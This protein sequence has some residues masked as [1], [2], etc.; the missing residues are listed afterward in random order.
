MAWEAGKPLSIE[1]I[2]VQP[3]KAGEVRVKVSSC[4][5]TNSSVGD[6]CQGCSYLQS[7]VGGGERSVSQLK[8]SASGRH[9]QDVIGYL[10]L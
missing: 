2:E 10:P 3:P 1:T 7:C 5:Y 4:V 6:A 9:N 8:T